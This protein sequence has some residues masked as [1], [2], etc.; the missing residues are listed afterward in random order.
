MCTEDNPHCVKSRHASTTLY[1]LEHGTYNGKP[2]SKVLL[3][4]H[5]GM[6]PSLNFTI[7]VNTRC[8]RTY[9]GKFYFLNFE[10]LNFRR[11]AS[12]AKIML[13]ESHTHLDIPLTDHLVSNPLSRSW[14]NV[15]QP[16]TVFTVEPG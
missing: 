8:L 7:S 15:T 14:H 10:N 16:V 6:V 12:K 3:V 2:V 5:T 4:P 11:N 9:F 1:L 13:L